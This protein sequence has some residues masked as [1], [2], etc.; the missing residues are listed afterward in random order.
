M[1]LLLIICFIV[2]GILAIALMFCEYFLQRN[3]KVYDFR[4]MILDKYIIP[5]ADQEALLGKDPQW[6][7]DMHKSMKSYDKMLYSFKSLKPENWI[8]KEDLEKLKL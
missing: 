3:N 8:S 2:L 1:D 5:K 7:F 4:M 6:V